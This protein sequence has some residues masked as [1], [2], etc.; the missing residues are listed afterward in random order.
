MIL[1]TPEEIFW[2]Q[3]QKSKN[4][5]KQSKGDPAKASHGDIS[6]DPTV[7]LLHKYFTHA[8]FPGF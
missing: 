1:T 2:I 3:K 6:L 4:K 7:S 8:L 5:A